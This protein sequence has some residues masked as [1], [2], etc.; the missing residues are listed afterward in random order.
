MFPCD[1]R[2]TTK[3]IKILWVMVTLDFGR[4]MGKYSKF[5]VFSVLTSVGYGICSYHQGTNTQKE[6]TRQIINNTSLVAREN[7]GNYSSF[8]F[9][10]LLFAQILK[11][12][13]HIRAVVGFCLLPFCIVSRF[14]VSALLQTM[15]SVP[16]CHLGISL[17]SFA[18][19]H[20]QHCK[21]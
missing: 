16:S 17:M 4:S 18:W 8:P 10:L 11:L 7:N 13:L 6:K 2:I 3:A 9:A 15:L 14:G 19:I 21:V 20:P 12:H 1:V 5:W